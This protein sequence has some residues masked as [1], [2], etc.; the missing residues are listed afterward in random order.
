MCVNKPMTTFY[1]VIHIF[2]KDMFTFNSPL[3]LMLNAFGNSGL[4]KVEQATT[5]GLFFFKLLSFY[6]KVTHNSCW[7]T[8][9]SKQPVQH[10][11]PLLS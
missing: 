2:N 8:N 4:I 9:S 6:T 11:C 7:S 1:C 10:A 5:L 3:L